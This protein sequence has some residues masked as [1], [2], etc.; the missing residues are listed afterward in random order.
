MRR[1]GVYTCLRMN[2]GVRTLGLACLAVIGVSACGEIGQPA[3]PTEY[4]PE[5]ALV[6]NQRTTVDTVLFDQCTGEDIALS[7]TAHV[8]FTTTQSGA[9]FHV[10]LHADQR[11]TGTGLVSGRVYQSVSV[12]NFTMN[13][14]GVPFEQT[15]V[16]S[17]RL[18]RRGGGGDLFSW[19]LQ[20]IVVDAGGRLRVFNSN[21][22]FECV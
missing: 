13:V 6:A 21:F 4:R 9:G 7:G 17:A 12:D 3:S 2:R 19:F 1:A 10:K 14:A 16:G 18:L 20:H 11:L 22:R 5:A 8:V 15:A